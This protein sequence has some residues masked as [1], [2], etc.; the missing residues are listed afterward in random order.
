MDHLDAQ[1]CLLNWVSLGL[2]PGGPVADPGRTGPGRVQPGPNPPPCLP[3]SY[4]VDLRRHHRHR[5][6]PRVRARFRPGRFA[7]GSSLGGNRPPSPR[8]A[9]H[10]AGPVPPGWAGRGSGRSGPDWNTDRPPSEHPAAHAAGPGATRD[11]LEPGGSGRVG[12]TPHVGNYTGRRASPARP[13]PW[14]HPGY[15]R[16]AGSP[17][18]YQSCRC[19]PGAGRRGSR[20]GAY[21]LAR[22]AVCGSPGAPSLWGRQ[23]RPARPCT[24]GCHP[25]HLLAWDI[26]NGSGILIPLTKPHKNVSTRTYL[27]RTS[28]KT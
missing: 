22:A 26:W 23:A 28:T 5:T 19:R 12:Q 20:S 6:Q 9:A 18:S 25:G 7:V 15:S 24:M 16:C 8:L 1:V 10:A 11:P 27:V 3:P 13:G 2:K 17:E 21:C 14:G 4:A